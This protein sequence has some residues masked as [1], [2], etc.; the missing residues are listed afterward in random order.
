[1]AST[2]EVVG[3]LDETLRVAGIEDESLNGLQVQ[4]AKEVSRVGLVTDAALA[5]SR[6]ARDEGCQ[7]IVAHHGLLWK[8]QERRVTGPWREHLGLLFEAGINLYGAHL[9]LDLHPELGNNAQLARIGGLAD[10][11]PFGRYHGLDIGFAGTLG[12]PAG[13]S[14]LAEAFARE[15]G[16]VPVVMPFG[17][18]RIR[19]VGIVSGGGGFAMTEAIERGLDCFVTGEGEHHH[20]HMALEHRLNVILLGHYHSETP[21]VKAVGDLLRHRFGVTAVFIDEPTLV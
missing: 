8:G 3:F 18:E 21:G 2:A 5:T 9:P 1:M 19:T 12:R 7:M 11:A 17:P 4:G 10:L 15:V 20:H 14:D 16:G 13:A 6:R